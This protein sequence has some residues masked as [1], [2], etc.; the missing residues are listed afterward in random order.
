MTCSII[1][2][3]AHLSGVRIEDRAHM[4]ARLLAICAETRAPTSSRSTAEKPHERGRCGP[5]TTDDGLKDV[6][7][8]KTAQPRMI[9]SRTCSNSHHLNAMWQLGW[10]QSARYPLAWWL[11][12]AGFMRLHTTALTLPGTDPL[13]LTKADP[14]SVTQ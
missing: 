4:Q 3:L 1:W 5:G 2:R 13:L 11:C 10:A 8:I 6:F 14:P 7:G 9:E 12:Q